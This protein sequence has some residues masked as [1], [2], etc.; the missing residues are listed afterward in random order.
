MYMHKKID[1][2]TI[3]EA[4]R[5]LVRKS[6][7]C[8]AVREGTKAAKGRRPAPLRAIELLE[9]PGCWILGNQKPG[10]SV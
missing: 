9:L 7:S 8:C 1:Q 6:S 2:Q 10:F 5:K 4:A 3:K